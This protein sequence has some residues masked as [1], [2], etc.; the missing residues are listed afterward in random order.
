MKFTHV[1]S[2][3]GLLGTHDTTTTAYITPEAIRGLQH[4]VSAALSMC[5]PSDPPEVL[6]AVEAA[7]DLLKLMQLHCPIAEPMLL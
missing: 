4:S 5:K 3:V 7:Y 6:H 2:N 1:I